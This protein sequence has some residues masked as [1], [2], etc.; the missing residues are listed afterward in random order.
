M[1]R[2]LPDRYYPTVPPLEFQ[3]W[4][5]WIDDELHRLEIALN[6]NPVLMGLANTG[7]I[8]INPPPAVFQ[9][10]GVG[11]IAEPEYPLGS[12]DPVVAE[13]VCPQDGT[14]IITAKATIE[15]FGSGNKSY[16][17][18]INTYIAGVLEDESI[19]SSVDDVPLTVNTNINVLLRSPQIVYFDVAAVHE[20]FSGTS[21]Y[22]MKLSILRISS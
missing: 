5:R 17:A 2:R 12:W 18:Q 10:L 16:Y 19:A 7:L 6:G 14:Y 11:V 9:R 4:P 8:D 21:D 1:A 13:W 20:Q 22:A 15:P 3:G